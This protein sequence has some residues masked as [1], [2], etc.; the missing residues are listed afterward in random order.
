MKYTSL[1]TVRSLIAHLACALSLA[2]CFAACGGGHGEEGCGES[3]SAS[4]ACPNAADTTEQECN[5]VCT[6]NG[7]LA[8]ERGCPEVYASYLECVGHSD[9]ICDEAALEAECKI[10]KDAVAKCFAG[11]G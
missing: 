3:C 1:Q 6:S 8:E 9:D 5:A 4:A 2:A 11:D 7:E 10:Q